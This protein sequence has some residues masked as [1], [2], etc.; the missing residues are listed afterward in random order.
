MSFVTTRPEG[1]AVSAGTPRGIDRAL[2]AANA[3]AAS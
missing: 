3:A 1:L 2:N